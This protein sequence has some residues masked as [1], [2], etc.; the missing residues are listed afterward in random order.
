MIIL[1]QSYILLFVRFRV[2]PICLLSKHFVT[3]AQLELNFTEQCFA[4]VYFSTLDV[5]SV[6]FIYVTGC[7]LAVI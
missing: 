3:G 2:R 7:A 4:S 1:F 5:L 6:K